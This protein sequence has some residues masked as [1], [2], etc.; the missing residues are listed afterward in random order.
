MPAKE[1]GR[2]AGRWKVVV[3]HRGMICRGHPDPESKQ[4]GFLPRDCGGTKDPQLCGI[5]I[6]VGS[7][8]RMFPFVTPC[9]V[10]VGDSILLTALVSEAGLPV[11]GCSVTVEATSPGGSVWNL[12][13]SD[14]GMHLDGGPDDGEYAQQ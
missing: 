6:G 13:L 2:Y 4:P 14:D 12:T 11:T 7:N 9:P 8:F 5:A 10:Y 1:P 3:Q